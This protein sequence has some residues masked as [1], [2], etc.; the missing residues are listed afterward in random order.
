MASVS[1]S[2]SELS[3]TWTLENKTFPSVQFSHSIVSDSL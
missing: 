1:V 2:F 3:T